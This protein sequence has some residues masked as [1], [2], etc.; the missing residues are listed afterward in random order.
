MSTTSE[1][2]LENRHDA[3]PK[4]KGFL[5]FVERV[6]NLLPDPFWLFVILAGLVAISSWV[7]SKVDMTATNPQDNS[8]VA[9]TNLLTKDGVS[10]M[11][12]EAV[13]NFV[14]FPPLGVILTVMLGVAVAEHSGFISALIRAMVAKVGPRTLTFVVALAGVTGSIAS[15]A[16]YV[17]LIPLGAMS[18]R[19]LGRS[20]IVGAMVAFAASSAGFNASLILNITDVLLG[21]ISTSAAQLVDPEYHVS[22][23]AN[24]FF[25]VASSIVLA[26]IIT[27]VTELFIKKKAR[28]L[29]DHDRIDHSELTFSKNADGS[30]GAQSHKDKTDDDLAEEIKLHP[31]EARALAFTGGAFVLMLAAY[32]ALL[33]IPASPLYSEEGA[34]T[35]PLI[36]AIAVPIAMMFLGLGIVYGVA[37]K[38]ITRLGDIPEFM[39][40]GLKTLIPM[41]VLFFM[42]AQFLA[43]FQWSNLGMWTA[44]K[45]AELLQQWDLPVYVLFGALV[46]MVALLNLAITS[47]SAQ[48]ALMAP[49]IVP[50]MMYI[51]VSPEVSQMLF[52]IGDSPTNIITPMSP[53]FALAL[54][55]LQRYYKPAGVGT[56]MSLAL[57]YSISMLVGWFLFFV[58]WY[59]LGIPIGPGTPIHYG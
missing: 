15:D 24:Y 47:G 36:K 53:Y 37:A 19:A 48:W 30:P 59:F 40:R 34:L 51:G 9:V 35:S 22:P 21:G 13:N 11:L 39:G 2:K 7:G 56:L 20:P 23:L 38:T 41:I 46:A 33:F 16:V 57:P 17:I 49:V 8:P 1:Q 43:W 14:S 52:R 4:P 27:L 3:P 28:E 44:I 50:M 42:V 25:V 31:G 29:V 10:R 54:T 45:G 58:L 32:F 26:L 5:G 6:G 12:T 18:F 55:F